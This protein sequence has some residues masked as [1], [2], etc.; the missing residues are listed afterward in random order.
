MISFY[1]FKKL[2]KN[3]KIIFALIE[4]HLNAVNQNL[5]NFNNKQYKFLFM[6]LRILIYNQIIFIL[7]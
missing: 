6:I 5:I 4:I 1:K 3:S 7:I 2:L